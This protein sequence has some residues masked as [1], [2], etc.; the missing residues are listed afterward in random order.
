MTG[1]LTIIVEPGKQ[2]VVMT[3]LFDVP[4]ERLFKGFTDPILVARW[5][6]PAKYTTTID[7]MNAI[8]GGVWRFVQRDAQGHEFAFHGVYHEVSFPWRLVNT[9]EF[10]G[11]PGHVSLET[12]TFEEQEGKTLL[13]QRAI[14]ES[15]EDRDAMIQSGMEAGASESMERLAT[16]M[17][18]G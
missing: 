6:G 5:W 4:R 2:Q 16:L 14:F 7:K 12:T 11:T 17:A 9:F 13:M 10:E 1:K 18:S 3:R 8:P 15:V